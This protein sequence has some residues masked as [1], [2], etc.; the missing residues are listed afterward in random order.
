LFSACR[1]IGIKNWPYRKVTSRISL[2]TWSNLHDF[3]F[4]LQNK[5]QSKLSI[6][7]W[8]FPRNLVDCDTSN[9]LKST[10]CDSQPAFIHD[11]L[12][13]CTEPTSAASELGLKPAEFGRLW[14]SCPA[15]KSFEG[16]IGAL[17]P[18]ENPSDLAVVGTSASFLTT[19]HNHPVSAVRLDSGS[20]RL[21]TAASAASA[22]F[23]ISCNILACAPA[24]TASYSTGPPPEL[25]DL[26]PEWL[27]Q[28]EAS[29]R[30]IDQTPTGDSDGSEAPFALSP[31]NK[32]PTA[33][34]APATA[35]AV[36]PALHAAAAADSEIVE[37]IT[38]AIG[39]ADPFHADWPFW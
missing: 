6:S 32:M 19:G 4:L 9:N 25:V 14:R 24:Q 11:G 3:A 27:P 28:H 12:T 13:V 5:S 31:I 39:E 34:P 35:D 36:F 18:L 10:D 38:W 23:R 2:Y 1:K 33:W 22:L 16:G 37:P 17:A 26:S 15:G 8:S 29:C 20:S 21:E 7:T 30:R